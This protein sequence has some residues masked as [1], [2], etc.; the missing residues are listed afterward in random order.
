[1]L[2]FLKYL[3]HNQKGIVIFTMLQNNYLNKMFRKLKGNILGEYFLEFLEN[4]STLMDCTVG[5][6]LGTHVNLGNVVLVQL[7]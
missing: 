5:F 7:L 2:S 1:M 4:S 3:T 6:R